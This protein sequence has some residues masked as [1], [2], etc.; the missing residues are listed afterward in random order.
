MSKSAQERVRRTCGRGNDIIFAGGGGSYL[1]G[2]EGNNDLAALA[3]GNELFAGA[4]NDTLN[5]AN[6]AEG[7][8]AA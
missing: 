4:G 6:D 8:V 5:A 1:D 3:G 2:E 7:R